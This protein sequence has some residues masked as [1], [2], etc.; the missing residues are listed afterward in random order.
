[1][2]M[3]RELLKAP[4][5]DWRDWFAD[6]TS[7]VILP[8][9]LQF[10]TSF[11]QSARNDADRFGRALMMSKERDSIWLKGLLAAQAGGLPRSTGK[12]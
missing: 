8:N 5:R 10:A 12:P 7:A 1:M 9:C 6:R 3:P 11:D 2:K 4:G